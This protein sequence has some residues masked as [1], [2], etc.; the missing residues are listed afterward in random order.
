MIHD[1]YTNMQICFCVET[2]HHLAM[3]AGMLQDTTQ[4]DQAHTLVLHE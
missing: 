3:G 4:Y 1:G 2:V